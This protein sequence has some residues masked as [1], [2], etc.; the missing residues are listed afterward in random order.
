[1]AIDAVAT[2]K[3][4]TDTTWL[5]DA[6]ASIFTLTLCVLG[7]SVLTTAALLAGY[8]RLLL[9]ILGLFPTR[10][11]HHCPVTSPFQDGGSTENVPPSNRGPFSFPFLGFVAGFLST[12]G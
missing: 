10:R 4:D 2:T 3:Y 8:R 9:V 12:D 5:G 7:G 11:Y 1:M 6:G